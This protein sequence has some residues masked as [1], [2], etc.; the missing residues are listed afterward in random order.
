MKNRFLQKFLTLLITVLIA[1]TCVSGCF[2]FSSNQ[3]V[4]AREHTFEKTVI[5]PTC[6]TAGYDL[7]TCH[8]GCEQEY[9][10]NIVQALGHNFNNYQSDNN[11]TLNADGTKTA[12]CENFGCIAT[13]TILE[14][15][16]K[17][18][19]ACQV[20]FNASEDSVFVSEVEKGQPVSTPNDPTK[21]NH[22]FIGWFDVNGNKYDFSTPVTSNLTLQAK[23]EIDAVKITN[24]ITTDKIKGVVKIYNKTY[25][26]SFLGDEKDVSYSQGSG[27]CFKIVGKT[28]YLLTN[29][30]VAYFDGSKSY[31]EYIIED[32]FGNKYTGYLYNNSNKKGK[33]IAS[34]Y[35]LACLYF[36]STDTS[37]Q[38]FAFADSDPVA[39]DDII[40][41]GSPKGQ[42]N[43][44]TFGKVTRYSKVTLSGSSKEESNVV[45]PVICSTAWINNGSSGGPAIN[46]KYQIIGVSYAGRD[47]NSIG[48][49]IPLSKVKEFLNEYVYS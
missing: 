19:G 17:L 46:A 45:F 5:K 26:K 2:D 29:C 49:Q 36:N 43:A 20:T 6:T 4:I 22:L 35:D 33:A 14:Y 21:E 13:H 47:D 10:K 37:V 1:L 44:I 41:L 16:T 48:Y 18:K 11:A 9:F 24:A 42:K 38:A 39:N 32:C 3:K 25:N 31:Q 23:Y 34:S 8:C 7:Y 28:H 15:G 40:A 12:R 27:F 30:H